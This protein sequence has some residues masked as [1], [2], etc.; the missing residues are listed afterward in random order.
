MYREY[1]TVEV[2]ASFNCYILYVKRRKMLNL[3]LI[4]FHM[5]N[6][7]TRVYLCFFLPI[8]V[9]FFIYS[10]SPLNSNTFLPSIFL[11]NKATR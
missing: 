1:F 8:F 2:L 11:F 6:E 7:S 5:M 9:N 3:E 4:V 10:S